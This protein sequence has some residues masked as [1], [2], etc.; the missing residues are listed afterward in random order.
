MTIKA[1]LQRL[2]PNRIKNIIKNRELTIIKNKIRNTNVKYKVYVDETK[3][4]SDKVAIVTGGSG[5]IGSAISMKLAMDG[6][7]VIITGRNKDNLYSVLNQIKENNG[8][9]EILELDVTDYDNIKVQFEQVYKKY[10]KIDILVNNAG[11]SARKKNNSILEQSVEVI[12][13]ILDINLRGTMLCCKEAAKY[14][15]DNKYG[16]IINIGS[17]VAVG[18]LAKFSEYCA[19]KA[20]VI[21]FTKSLA[22]ELAPYGITVNCVSPGI[23]NQIIWDKQLPDFPSDK[24]YIGRIG[25]TDDIANAVEFFAKDESE[26]I[27]GQNLIVDGGRSLGLKE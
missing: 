19:S 3:K 14:M 20:G 22:M 21:G 11:G 16:R 24:N 25:K 5:A 27:I 13:E 6:A 8:N 2:I 17:T 23:T 26:F 18:G 15:R 4:M 1:I 10:G 12:D 7:T 9:A